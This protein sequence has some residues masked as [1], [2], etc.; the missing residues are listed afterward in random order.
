MGRQG[1]H[2][3]KE[4]SAGTKDDRA[5][6]GNLPEILRNGKTVVVDFW[7]G[8]CATCHIMA[9]IL[10]YMADEFDGRVAFAKVDVPNNR[11]LAEQFKIKSIPTLVFP[12]KEWD[13]VIGVRSHQELR[14]VL[15]DV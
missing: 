3:I 4:V 8:W 9:P 15:A 7:A 11:D 12:K 13:R 2:F 14:K 5:T 6:L 1:I 10:R